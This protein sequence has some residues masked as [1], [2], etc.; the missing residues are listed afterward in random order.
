MKAVFLRAFKQKIAVGEADAPSLGPHDVLVQVE[1]AGVCFK[2]VLVVDGFQPRVKLP[3]VLGHEA[4]GRIAAVGDDVSGFAVG[5]R[6]C[7]L[8]YIP[9]GMCSSCLSGS[10]HICRKRQWLGEDQ[11]GAYAQYVRSR[12][13]ALVTIPD[14]IS[15]EAAAAATCAVGTV[16]H[17]LKRLAN[18]KSGE[19]V[20]VTGA[21]GAVGSN[22]VLVANAMG[23]RT[24]ATDVPDKLR[25]IQ[26]ADEV[27][28]F[29]DQLSSEVKQRTGGEGVD[30]A[31]E[32]V[33][34]PTFEQAL[35]SLRWGGR[36]VV[37]GNVAPG[38]SIPLALG[39][40]ILREN[41]ILGCMNS[42]KADLAD[43]LHLIADGK[44]TP[45]SPTVLPL[46]DAQH[47]HDLLRQRKSVG[48]I[49]LRP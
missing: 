34:T 12:V 1:A 44:L 9:C 23:A 49:I 18:L 27:V 28:P 25:H 45:F 42:T 16:V 8:G 41:A 7:S 21:A 38:D 32:A 35:R 33:G 19:T 3:V 37:I 40:V 11:D 17:G 24:I 39:S 43:A 48:K 46:E 31:L 5:D 10:E 13:D 36:I 20:L 6:V 30:L 15:A 2:D 47:A 4:A 26:G 14:G 22:A 29:T